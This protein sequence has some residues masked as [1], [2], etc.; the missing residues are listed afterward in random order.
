MGIEYEIYLRPGENTEPLTTKRVTGVLER[1][2]FESAD[3]CMGEI[4]MDHGR[5][6]DRVHAGSGWDAADASGD[7]PDEQD[8]L[9]GVDFSFPLGM[10]DIEG[11]LAVSR[12]LEAGELL[13]AELYDPQLGKT[14]SHGDHERIIAAWR[15]S[16]EF[17]FGVAGSQG[18]GTGMPSAPAVK[19]GGIPG[20]Y[21]VMAAIAGAIL[22]V[23]LMV[24]ACVKQ[25]LEEHMYPGPPTTE[26]QSETS[27]AEDRGT[28]KQELH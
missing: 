17:Q 2:Q 14:V 5:L 6:V 13:Q 7:E 15:Q 21:K 24:R 1:V 8:P 25:L 10:P 27:P 18:L 26:A 4:N 16:H 9:K 23:I 22:I 12:I 11:D 3:G 20:R 28:A 19:S